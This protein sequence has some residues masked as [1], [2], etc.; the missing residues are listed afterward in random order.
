MTILVTGA[1]GFL[2]QYVVREALA[3][4]HRVRAIVRPAGKLEALPWADAANLELV[5]ADLRS[6]AGLVKA[7]D[8]VDAVIHAAAAKSG[9]IYAQMAGTVV[10]TE[11]L[12]WAMHQAGVKRLVAV[13]TFSVYAYSRMWTWSELN[14]SSPT[15][16]NG[17]DRDEYAIT[18][19]IQESLVLDAAKQPGWHVTVL[20]PGV[21]Y[22]RNNTWTARLGAQSSGGRAWLRIGAFARLPLTYVENCAEALLLAAETDAASG[23]VLNVVDDNPPTQRRYLRELRNRTQPRPRIVP[24]PYFLMR[25]L[26]ALAWL[27]NKF[28][29]G[30]RAKLPG[31]LIPARLHARFKPLRFNNAKIKRT[32]G[33]TPRYDL[34]QALDRSFG[35][36]PVTTQPEPTTPATE[37]AALAV[38]S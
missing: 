7:L 33:W 19:L 13:S 14:E 12:L 35:T 8:G 10:A 27:V 23:Q 5:R 3:R 24:V 29:L 38:H 20:R 28:L 2:G 21:I 37:A 32:L 17:Y 34:K 18:K 15:E 30:G 25:A 26:A 36:A 22:G 6:R 16:S 4:G 11:N 31:I 1:T 9:D